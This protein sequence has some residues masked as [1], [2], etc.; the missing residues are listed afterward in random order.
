M[1]NW[2]DLQFQLRHC[3]CPGHRH[4][5]VRWMGFMCATEEWCYDDF[6]SCKVFSTYHNSRIV[7][8]SIRSRKQKID[9]IC[10]QELMYL[11][12]VFAVCLM[13]NST[14]HLRTRRS[15]KTT[16]QLTS[17]QKALTKPED[18]KIFVLFI[19]STLSMHTVHKIKSQQKMCRII[20]GAIKMISYMYIWCKLV[21]VCLPGTI[22]EAARQPKILMQIC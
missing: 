2:H 21:V 12:V 7:T 22:K 10:S 19:F 5:P 18:G 4:Q 1:T 9:K 13:H 14:I 3:M 17:L 16:S 20:V 15:L 11:I 8:H 6:D